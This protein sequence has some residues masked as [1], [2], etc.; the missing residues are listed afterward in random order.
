VGAAIAGRV[1]GDFPFGDPHFVPTLKARRAT[2]RFARLRPRAFSSVAIRAACLPDEIAAPR[3]NR[4]GARQH[5]GQAPATRG[6]TPRVDGFKGVLQHGHRP[7]MPEIE[8]TVETHDA[9]S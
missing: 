6:P 7:M 3:R 8:R 9:H 1:T 4:A 5:R 2:R